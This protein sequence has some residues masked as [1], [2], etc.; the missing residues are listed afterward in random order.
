[1]TPLLEISGLEV[2]V[3]RT[4]L[5]GPVTVSLDSRGITAVLGPN[6][7]GKSLFLH[8]IHGLIPA[9]SGGVTWAGRAASE[10]RARRGFVFQATPVMRRSVFANVAFPLAAAGIRGAERRARVAAA[11]AQARLSGREQ[12]PAARLSGGERQR[13]A[14][15]RAV[16]TRPDAV[17]LD[18]PAANLDP[19]STKELEAMLHEISGNGTKIMIATHD[20]AQA[21]RL[22]GDVLF[23]D[24]GRLI[25]HSPSPAFFEDAQDRTVRRYLE[26]RL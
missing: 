24:S 18:E 14:L 13:M 20:L 17:L 1:M 19:A 5:L 22:A 3:D 11:L 2:E 23:F 9:D 4:H 8:A 7:A 26:G 21:R 6:G 10:T 12:V 15:A 25:A 16:V